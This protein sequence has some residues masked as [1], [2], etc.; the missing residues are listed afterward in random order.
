[1][2]KRLEL[3]SE[4]EAKRLMGYYFEHAVPFSFGVLSN[5]K[6]ASMSRTVKTLK[7]LGLVNSRKRYYSPQFDAWI[8]QR[9]IFFITDKGL[10]FLKRG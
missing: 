7:K 3:L 2:S 10:N 6:P 8:R 5:G 1:M 9:I 4:Y